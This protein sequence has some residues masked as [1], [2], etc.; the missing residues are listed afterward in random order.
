MIILIGLTITRTF[1]Y[2]RL[3]KDYSPL[4]T[5]LEKVIR[6]LGPFLLFF[7]ILVAILSMAFSILQLEENGHY[8]Y[9]GGLV[10][11][12]IDTLKVSVGD[13]GVIDSIMGQDRAIAGIFWVTFL[14]MVVTMSIIFLNFVIAEAS[15]S[16]E[17]VSEKLD[18]FV[19]RELAIF[20]HEAEEMIPKW[21]KSDKMLPK[22][23]IKRQVSS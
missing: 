17:E 16:Y 10:G 7:I 18:E 11:G 3:F 4:V 1:R 14:I 20:N 9:V 12:F 22:F 2:M 21:I 13:F 19:Q 5:M 15:A 23:I 6:D 8:E